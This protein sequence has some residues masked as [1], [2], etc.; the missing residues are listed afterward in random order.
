MVQTAVAG[1]HALYIQVWPILPTIPT[2]QHVRPLRCEISTLC[3]IAKVRKYRAREAKLALVFRGRT[4]YACTNPPNASV[5]SSLTPLCEAYA[6]Y[7]L[8]ARPP[9]DKKYACGSICGP[10]RRQTEKK[11]RYTADG[12][13]TTRTVSKRARHSDFQS[14]TKQ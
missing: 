2:S 11:R 1:M 12:R 8:G 13:L 6:S 3:S 9:R 7:S 5:L 4:L 10:H 14:T